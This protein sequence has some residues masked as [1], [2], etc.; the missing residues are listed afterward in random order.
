MN[1]LAR[2]ARVAIA[3]VPLLLIVFLAGCAP[4]AESALLAPDLGPK[5]VLA[6]SAG[7]VEI[8]PT[9]VPP[10]FA[11]LTPDQVMAGLDPAV[12]EAIANADASSGE[13]IALTF[14]C[15]GCHSLNPDDVRTGPT[16]HNVG[17][18]AVIRVPGESPAQ[19]IYQSITA[20][21]AF[22]V[23]GYPA[24]IMPANFTDLMTPEQIADMVAY[25]LQQH[26]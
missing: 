11:E 1:F 5:L 10:K 3:V 21:N 19:Y 2:Y 9:P 26:E 23:P 4:D 24:N 20:P 6:Q 16:W 12:Q 17:D 22:V 13:T 7:E 15:I 18:T 25:L 8:A 14:G